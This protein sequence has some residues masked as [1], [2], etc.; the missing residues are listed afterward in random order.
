[1]VDS[2][3]LLVNQLKR[4]TKMYSALSHIHVFFDRTVS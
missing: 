3:V 2:L 4:K 1:V